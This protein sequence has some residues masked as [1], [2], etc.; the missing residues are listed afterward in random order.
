MI[1]Q[2]LSHKCLHGP[3]FGNPL[4]YSI[5]E[6]KSKADLKNAEMILINKT[7]W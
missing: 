1:A 5:E 2:N 4:M 3:T 6:R 7:E